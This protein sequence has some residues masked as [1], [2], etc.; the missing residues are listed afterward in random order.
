MASFCLSAIL[1]LLS[2]VG[3]EPVRVQSEHAID[4]GP[5]VRV[6]G[7]GADVWVA[8]VL[9]FLFAA[10][11]LFTRHGTWKVSHSGRCSP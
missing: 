5:I 7:A 10:G 6:H 2:V 3:G 8:L 9:A 4:L 1:S 11:G